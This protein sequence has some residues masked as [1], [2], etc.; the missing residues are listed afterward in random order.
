MARRQDYGKHMAD[1]FA[2]SATGTQPERNTRLTCNV[3]R[4]LLFA[5]L[6]E[7]HQ[8]YAGRCKAQCTMKTLSM[9]DYF[10][11]RAF[12]RY[13]F[14]ALL[15][16]NPVFFPARCRRTANSNAT[17]LPFS[18]ARRTFYRQQRAHRTPLLV[19]CRGLSHQ[20]PFRP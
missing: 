17:V 5:F 6:S 1:R 19:S 8:I 18:R 11:G 2:A 13:D 20:M 3:S 15:P 4:A 16:H 12:K 7:Q 14:N 10:A 9:D